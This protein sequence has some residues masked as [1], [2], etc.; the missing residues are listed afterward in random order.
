MPR[1]AGAPSSRGVRAAHVDASL[2][3]FNN[4]SQAIG[5]AAGVSGLVHPGGLK[6]PDNFSQAKTGITGGGFN[7]VHK[8][9]PC[10]RFPSLAAGPINHAAVCLRAL[11]IPLD[12]VPVAQFR[13]QSDRQFW[14]IIYD[15]AFSA[16]S[17]GAAV[18]NRCGVGLSMGAVAGAWI[19]GNGGG[20]AV[21]NH[22]GGPRFISRRVAGG[23][24]Q[25]DILAG[26]NGAIDDFNRVEFRIETP[27]GP[28]SYSLLTVLLNNRSIFSADW[29]NPI[30]AGLPVYADMLNAGH[31]YAGWGNNSNGET[32]EM[33]LSAMRIIVSHTVA[34]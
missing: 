15:V 23:I 26:W 34:G 1:S 25:F 7:Y 19:F 22:P 14:R 12:P 10:Y 6:S 16:L 28:G 4:A 29:N 5:G 33:Y 11:T 2:E 17:S 18:N 27:R 24:L 32:P 31:F 20:F 13:E 8:N 21:V 9:R 3:I 30:G